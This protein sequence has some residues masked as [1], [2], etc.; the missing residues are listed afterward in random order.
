MGAFKLFADHYTEGFEEF[1]EHICHIIIAATL[2][3]L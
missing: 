3:Q 2:I 1:L